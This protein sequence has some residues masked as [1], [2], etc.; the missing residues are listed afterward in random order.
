MPMNEK[1]YSSERAYAQ[2]VS[3]E[4]AKLNRTPTLLDRARAANT[5]RARL[6]AS[7]KPSA[8]PAPTLAERW[9]TAIEAQR[10]EALER[11]KRFADLTAGLPAND[12]V[13]LSPAELEDLR[14]IEALTVDNE[15][16]ETPAETPKPPASV[17]KNPN[18][19]PRVSKARDRRNVRILKDFV[20]D[21]RPLM[22]PAGVATPSPLPSTLLNTT[23]TKKQK[24]DENDKRAAPAWRFTTEI[25]KG[26]CC[27]RSVSATGPGLAWSLNIGGKVLQ[28]A[29]D[30][31][32][33]FKTWIHDRL[34]KAFRRTLGGPRDFVFRLEADQGG[35]VHLHGAI[36]ATVE[37]RQAVKAALEMAGGEWTPGHHRERQADARIQ[38]SA[39]G[40]ARYTSKAEARTKRVM[41]IDSVL[42]VTR[43]CNRRARELWESARR[44]E[45]HS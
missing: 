39:D 8:P 45:A 30:N 4:L 27:F 9:K 35:R 11:R 43:G 33:R 6:S 12:D 25:I 22:S 7:S 37:E 1:N 2:A 5:A 21:V 31:P 15:P 44:N 24:A 17:I 28:Y 29:N 40:W 18:S 13:E 23:K 42:S 10:A 41:G 26:T 16:Q 38:F 19:R 14:T 20:P 34:D 32:K 36:D 3:Y